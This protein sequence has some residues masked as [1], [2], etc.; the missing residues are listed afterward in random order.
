[1]HVLSFIPISFI[2][3]RSCPFIFL[4]YLVQYTYLISSF[5]QDNERTRDVL[6]DQR[7][8]KTIIG[9]GGASIKEIRERFNQVQISFP[10]STKQ[11]DIV[12]LRGP[13]DDV[14]KVNQYLLKVSKDMVSF[15][16]VHISLI[17]F[18]NQYIYL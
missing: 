7:F 13:K 14:D 3:F 6:I 8:H 11:S 18:E 15:E 9:T 17:G 12:T 16:P 10:D 1:M 2:H 5:L 4:S